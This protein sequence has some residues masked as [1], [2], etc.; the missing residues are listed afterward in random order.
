MFLTCARTTWGF[1]VGLM[2]MRKPEEMIV[3]IVVLPIAQLLMA[4]IH[5]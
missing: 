2:T 5:P 1:A 3:V 4:E